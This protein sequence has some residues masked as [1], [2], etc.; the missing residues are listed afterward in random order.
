[1]I[2]IKHKFVVGRKRNSCYFEFIQFMLWAWKFFNNWDNEPVMVAENVKDFLLLLFLISI[3]LF[4]KPNTSA[5][6]HQSETVIW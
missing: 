6:G 4:C 5:K 1:M 3:A 2:R